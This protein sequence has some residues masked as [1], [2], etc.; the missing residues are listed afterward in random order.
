MMVSGR[1]QV[2]LKNP[3]N[4]TGVGLHSGVKVN[5]TLRPAA[6][7]SD[8]VFLRTDL[9]GSG[10]DGMVPARWDRVSDTMLGTTIAN[11]DG[12][13]VATIEHLMAAFAGCGVDNALVEIDG[14][15]LP[16]MDG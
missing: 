6:P 16:I 4:C 14:P 7:G 1:H 2:T 13:K 11:A 5:M 15:E 10:L 3:I 12:V 8:I 9:A